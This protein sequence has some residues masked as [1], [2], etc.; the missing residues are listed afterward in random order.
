[1]MSLVLTSGSTVTIDA[2]GEDEEKA[3][4]ELERFL[5]E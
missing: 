2:E 3:V 4:V 1:M 5:T